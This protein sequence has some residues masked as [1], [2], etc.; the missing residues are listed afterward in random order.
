VWVAPDKIACYSEVCRLIKPGGYFA[1][2][3]WCVT[4]KYDSNNPRHVAIREGIE[5]GNG[6]PVLAT[7]QQVVA[8]LEKSGFEVLDHFNAQQHTH[9]PGQIPWYQ[10]LAGQY[11]IEGFR[12]T[13]LGRTVTHLLVSSLEMLGI[14][15]KG[16]TKVSQLLNQTAVD[17]VEGGKLEIFTPSYFVLARK[18]QVEA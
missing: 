2:Y 8:A 18:K 12:M 6:L 16:S 9:V 14:A 3:E 17:L 7:P 11:T 5:I 4:D 10:T 13:F 1:T 15:P